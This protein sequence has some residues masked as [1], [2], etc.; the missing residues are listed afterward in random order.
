[1]TQHSRIL[2]I[3]VDGLEGSLVFVNPENY[4]QW[5]VAEELEVIK[6]D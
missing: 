4:F 6:R 2:I 1:M 5:E 3:V